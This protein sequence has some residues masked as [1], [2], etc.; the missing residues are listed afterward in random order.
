MNDPIKKAILIYSIALFFIAFFT[1]ANLAHAGAQPPE[2]TAKKTLYQLNANGY[3]CLTNSQ[4]E[5]LGCPVLG[6]NP[7]Y[8]APFILGTVTTYNV[9][10]NCTTG[11]APNTA[12]IANCY[13]ANTVQGCPVDALRPWSW[14]GTTCTRPGACPSNQTWDANLNQCVN[15][16]T[17]KKGTI[18]S[19]G[20][21][22]YGTNPDKPQ[23]ALIN[24]CQDGCAITQDFIDP[25]SKQGLVGGVMHYYAYAQMSYT[26]DTCTPSPD[27]TP[28]TPYTT[29]PPQTCAPG[30]T[31]VMNA[32]KTKLN[33]YP[34]PGM[35]SGVPG[36]GT[37]TDS[38]TG[39]GGAASGVP[40]AGAGVAG[41]GVPATNIPAS[42]VDAKDPCIDN[43]DRAACSKL[44]NT[45]TPEAIETKEIAIDGTLS[46]I[47]I[48]NGGSCPAD[49]VVTISSGNI[50]LRY[51]PFCDF[52]AIFRYAALIVGAMVAG[53]ILLGQRSSDS[54]G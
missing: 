2:T 37:G 17:S 38:G 9:G 39:T 45:F 29:A 51:Q 7:T 8:H 18:A 27:N 19:S 10:I 25:P 33:C 42:G 46:S 6:T 20:L 30:D 16:C 43:P 34:N 1:F 49:K 24:A 5:L 54:G 12:Q 52:L 14:N 3:S 40:G 35:G 50:T 4:S 26:G 36:T 48:G 28:S 13:V 15:A 32:A 11:T 31:P 44:E 22:D 47:T 21:F 53:L 41:S 23:P